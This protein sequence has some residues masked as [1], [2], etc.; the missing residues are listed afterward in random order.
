M[1]RSFSN[2]LLGGVCGGLAERTPIA[3]WLW[4]LLFT[5]LT[6]WTSGAAALAYVLMW[7]LL[8]LASP[9]SARNGS[10]ARGLLALVGAAALIAA[11][12]AQDALA[13]TLGVAL[14]WPL[15]FLLIAAIYCIQQITQRQTGNLGLGLMVLL[16]PLVFVAEAF[17]L[18]PVGLADALQRAWPA[19]LVFF[20]L[21]VLLRNRLRIGGL[22]A[23]SIS[24][25][26]VAG[27]AA[28]GFSAREGTIRTENETMLME[29]VADEMTLLQ[30]NLTTRDTSVRVASNTGTNRRVQATYIGSEN[31]SFDETYEEDVS[32]GIATLTLDEV[33]IAEFPALEDVGRGTLEIALPSD[34]ALAIAYVGAD[35]GTDGAEFDLAS[36]NLE[37][38]NLI[39][40]RGDVLV[41]LPDYQPLSPSVQTEPGTWTVSNG[42]LR[43][44]VPEMVGTRFILSQ[45]SNRQPRI[46]ESFDELVY[47]LEIGLN[48]WFL[49][50]R[51]FDALDVQLRYN[52]NV[53]NGTV[54][55]DTASGS[56]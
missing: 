36:L 3:A 2:R 22:L 1:Y 54:R 37:R 27:V 34:V 17:T 26:L 9:L 5:V 40:N 55:I 21:S 6:I 16:V 41:T 32:T 46:G 10:W 31:I 12:F 13:E 33:Q 20:G 48:E 28:I 14:Y 44:V 43:V 23:L 53:P 18:F 47:A 24:V 42:S 25:A 35:A 11:W 8:P 19:L 15:A 39:L 49:V 45:S 51:R 38:L 7:W 56:D 50:S 52:V 30:L 29:T 4:R